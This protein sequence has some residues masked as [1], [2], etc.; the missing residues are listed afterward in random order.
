VTRVPLANGRR[1]LRLTLVLDPESRAVVRLQEQGLAGAF[2][3]QVVSELLESLETGGE[4]PPVEAQ[5][6]RPFAWKAPQSLV[7]RMRRFV[8]PG[9]PYSCLSH[10]VRAAIRSTHDGR[11]NPFPRTG[12]GRRCAGR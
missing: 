6:G 3:R 1:A 8:G 11:L 10:V 7:D 4:G 5:A 9:Q 2:L 12:P